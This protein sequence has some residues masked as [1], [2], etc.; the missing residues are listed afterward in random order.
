MYNSATAILAPND[1]SLQHV[2]NIF[3]THVHLYS[4][5]TAHF[6]TPRR[7]RP[8]WRRG[9]DYF[10]LRDASPLIYSGQVTDMCTCDT[11]SRIYLVWVGMHGSALTLRSRL[12]WRRGDDHFLLCD[13]SP[14]IYSG[15]VTDMCTCDTQSRIYLVWVG[16]HGSA[17][18][19]RSR[20]RWRRGDDHFLLC[21]VSP[22]IYSGQV[23]DMCTCDTQSREYLYGWACM[24][25]H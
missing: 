21:D 1:Q 19:L 9:D 3:H 23:T 12:R 8:R 14:L 6:N 10:L 2:Y 11:Q 17:L 13:V 15:Q 16:M 22:L 24:A 5:S 4:L 20:L 25:V 7:S 18:T